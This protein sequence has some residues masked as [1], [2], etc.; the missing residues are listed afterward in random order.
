MV[1]SQVAWAS[2]SQNTFLRTTDGGASWMAGRVGVADQLDFRDVEAFSA[3]TALLLSAGQPARVYRTD[4]GGESW[5]ECYED[6]SPTSF[7]D[8]MDFWDD[9]HGIAFSDPVHGAPHLI[10]TDDGGKNWRVISVNALPRTEEKEAGFAA[11]GTCL[12]VAGDQHVWIGT[13]GAVARVFCSADRGQSWSVQ[14]TPLLSG[15]PS[16]GVFSVAFFDDEIGIVA[17]GDFLEPEGMGANIAL[18]R[19][20][21][22]HW[23]LVPDSGLSGFRSCV[24]YVPGTNGRIVVAVGTSGTDVSF[25]GGE[26]WKS[27]GDVGYNA[28]SFSS[29]DGAGFA[30]GAEGRLARFVPVADLD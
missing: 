13:G 26:T 30:V 4:D 25:D 1:S 6:P 14:S 15:G 17:G 5:T 12:A 16:K 21:G 18:T 29:R 28:V 8:A 11:S 2:G 7:F 19:D 20:G 24:A 22:N 9:Q 23:K 27:T 3:D 10:E